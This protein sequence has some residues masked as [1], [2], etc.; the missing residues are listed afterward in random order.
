[1]NEFDEL[2]LK[3]WKMFDIIGKR[4]NG[5]IIYVL[6]SGFKC[7]S[8]IYS[9]IF[10]LSK[11]MLI[12]WMKELEEEGIVIWYVIFECLVCIEYIL[13]KKGLEFG[14]ILGFVSK[15]VKIW[16]K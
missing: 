15:W 3:V 14:M 11:W 2:C 4:W 16:I 7:F 6:M 9:S 10:F 1:M 8:E 12:E 13:I 5:L